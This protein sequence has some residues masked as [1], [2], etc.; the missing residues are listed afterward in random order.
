M[1]A[2]V[3]YFLRVQPAGGGSP[4]ETLRLAVCDCYRFEIGENHVMRA[5]TDRMEGGDQQALSLESLTAPLVCAM[6]RREGLHVGG[7]V[8]LLTRYS[9]RDISRVLRFTR[10]RLSNAEDRRTLG[11]PLQHY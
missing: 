4:E 7:D 3:K 6:R 10:F 9:R 8:L 11:T 1:V 5:E 2:T